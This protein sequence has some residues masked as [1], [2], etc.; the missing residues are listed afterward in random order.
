[1]TLNL[2]VRS[3]TGHNNLSYFKSK[4]D[5]LV[6]PL[7]RLCGKEN[8]TIYHMLTTCDPMYNK[9]QEL[10]IYEAPN[11]DR[12]WSIKKLERFLSLPIINSM[13][14]YDT[15]YEVKELIYQEHNYSSDTDSL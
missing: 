2:W 1:M 6:N 5:P 12:Q 15:T 11:G 3:I 14:S 10:G 4:S 8:E 7:C 13:L 9:K